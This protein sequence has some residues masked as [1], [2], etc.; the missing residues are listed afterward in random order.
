MCS[1]NAPRS[2]HCFENRTNSGPRYA[3]LLQVVGEHFSAFKQKTH[4]GFIWY[5]FHKSLEKLSF[6]ETIIIIIVI[7]IVITVDTIIFVIIFIFISMYVFVCLFV[8]LS[9]FLNDFGWC[10][11]SSSCPRGGCWSCWRLSVP[12]TFNQIWGFLDRCGRWDGYQEDLSM[13]YRTM[14]WMIYGYQ[15]GMHFFTDLI[16]WFFLKWGFFM[17]ESSNMGK[18][19]IRIQPSSGMDDRSPWAIEPHRWGLGLVISTPRWCISDL[20]MII[21]FPGCWL[22]HIGWI[23]NGWPVS[24]S[25]AM[26]YFDR[27]E[28]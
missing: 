6:G 1:I 8:F 28:V 17:I 14:G 26:T 20:R 5:H 3:L 16:H 15:D 11:D 13:K 24:M 9:I 27:I 25:V 23:T 19:R 12:R 2:R 22:L 7:I 10:I 21:T 4:H 18:C